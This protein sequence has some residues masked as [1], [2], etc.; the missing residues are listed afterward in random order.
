MNKHV[1]KVRKA[2]DRAEAITAG[3]QDVYAASPWQ[4]AAGARTPAITTT[5]YVTLTVYDQEED[6]R[7]RW[8]DNVKEDC[9]TL[10][11]TL[12]DADRLAKDRSG[13]RS[14]IHRSCEVGAAGAR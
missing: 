4:P 3:R 14:V 9:A 8:L 13:W 1:N 10:Q 2:T 11:L 7:K 5:V 12:P 6:P